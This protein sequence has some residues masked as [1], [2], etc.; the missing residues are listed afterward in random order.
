MYMNAFK[1]LNSSYLQNR[2]EVFGRKIKDYTKKQWGY[3]EVKKAIDTNGNDLAKN[4]KYIQTIDDNKLDH[5]I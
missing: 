4:Q 2:T 5:G 3:I 1:D